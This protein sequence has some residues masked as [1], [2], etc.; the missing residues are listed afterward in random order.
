MATSL[1]SVLLRERLYL[2]RNTVAS[3]GE[4]GT[5]ENPTR[6]KSVAFFTHSFS[7]EA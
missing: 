5:V 3:V 1:S 6:A 4:G 2:F 7:I